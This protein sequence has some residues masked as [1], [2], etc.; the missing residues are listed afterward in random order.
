VHLNVAH[1]ALG[2]VGGRSLLRVKRSKLELLHRAESCEILEFRNPFWP[3]P[4]AAV[5]SSN[6]QHHE[7]HGLKLVG[8]VT[9]PAMPIAFRRGDIEVDLSRCS[10]D[11]IGSITPAVLN[12]DNPNGYYELD[13]SHILCRREQ[14]A[15]PACDALA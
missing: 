6:T 10:I 14:P 7:Q 11:F 15:T 5:P 13:L 12:M 8:V 1:N 2:M 9:I 4:V 3:R